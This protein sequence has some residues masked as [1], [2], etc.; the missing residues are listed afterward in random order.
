M[1]P[2]VRD[3]IGDVISELHTLYRLNDPGAFRERL[4]T[5]N[6][7]VH[8]LTVVN[9]RTPKGGGLIQAASPGIVTTTDDPSL[10]ERLV[11]LMDQSQEVRLATA[12]LSASETN[13]LIEPLRRLGKNGGKARILTSLMGFFNR[14]D[15]LEVFRNWGEFLSLRLYVANPSEGYGALAPG[16]P[17]FHAKTM[18]FESRGNLPNVM[19]VGS[20]NMTGAGLS[21]NIE[22]NYISDFEVNASLHEGRTPYEDAVAM[23]DRLWET[24]GY[25]PDEEFIEQYREIHARAAKL[26]R[27]IRRLGLNDQLL[28]NQ[29]GNTGT[30]VS[31]ICPRPAQQI[32]LQRMSE[33]RKAGVKKF[34]VIAAT[35]IGKTFLSAFEIRNSG[36]KRALFLAHREAILVHAM[37]GFAQVLP[38]VKQVLIRGQDSVGSVSGDEL[39]VFAMVQTLSRPNNLQAIPRDYFEYIVVD[40]FHHASADSYRAVIEHF[41]AP[42]FLGMTATPER[43]DG[44]D[45]LELCERNVAY[46]V[47]LMEAVERRWLAPFQ[48]YALFDSTDYTKVKWTGQGYDETELERALSNDTRAELIINS[49]KRYQPAL[50]KYKCLAFCSNVGHAR[51]MAA[52]FTEF[53]FIAEIVVGETPFDQRRILLNRLQD[54]EDP[55]QIICAVDVLSE[56]VDVPQATHILL[57]RPTLSLT[58]FLQQVGRGLRLHP[59]KPFVTVLDFVGNY[60]KSYI[61]RM[62]LAGHYSTPDSSP[63]AV[64]RERLKL[65]DGCF[66]S[67]DTEVQRVWKKEIAALRTPLDRLRD[68]IDDLS[69]GRTAKDIRLPDLF[70][71]EDV[72]RY[73]TEIRNKGGWLAT[74]ST[75]ELD[76][77]T[78]YEKELIG[79]VG[80]AFLRHIELDLS[81]TRSYKMAVLGYLLSSCDST[82]EANAPISW[83]IAEI[84]KA[85]LAYYLGDNDRT[86]DWDALA[87]SAD[88]SS[89]RLSTTIT[90]VRDKPLRFL[91]NSEGSFFFLSEDRQTF[92]LVSSIH[93]YW[94][95]SRFRDLVRER[96]EFAEAKY[97]YNKRKRQQNPES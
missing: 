29:D 72:D 3:R 77:A 95:E 71:V 34:A 31:K 24:N 91:S 12:F 9:A 28:T 62:A 58:V 44:Q 89:F 79:T 50:G 87:E 23:F 43:A 21:D 68:V 86:N 11:E 41:T 66:V 27:E 49:L 15:T 6:R 4:D 63:A 53:G 5:I 93:P 85:F 46:E 94:Q 39:H 25:E 81:P 67:V 45:V 59:D 37:E 82:T 20:A 33:L 84:A 65:P 97:W 16:S 75:E 52:Q 10:L 18:L 54:E 90:H 26:Q 2:E 48:Y 60:R 55:L 17:A 88:P 57:L 51:W 1:N 40:E 69:E 70:T 96:V 73:L 13:P 47:R 92:G 78:D 22:W 7:A 61:K 38:A 76:I 19:A 35:G 30:E 80:E 36:A 32:A 64:L 8:E 42:H 56:G 74:K 83:D 14:P